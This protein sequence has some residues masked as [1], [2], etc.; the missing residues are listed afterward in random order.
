MYSLI[1]SIK[2]MQIN[3]ITGTIRIL[4]NNSIEEIF[5]GSLP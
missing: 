3:I 4:N 2:L 5:E 1:L